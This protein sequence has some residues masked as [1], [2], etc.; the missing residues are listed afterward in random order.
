MAVNRRDTTSHAFE[1][2]DVPPGG[3]YEPVRWPG[4]RIDLEGL[5]G[6]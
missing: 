2:L 5:S 4:L 6:D 1:R 3:V